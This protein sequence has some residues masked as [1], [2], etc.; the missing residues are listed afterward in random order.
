MK[1]NKLTI[2][3]FETNPIIKKGKKLIPLAEFKGPI[4]KLTTHDKQEIDLLENQL[5]ELD[6][7]YVTILRYVSTKRNINHLL[8]FYRGKLLDIKTSMSQIK[9]QIHNIKIAR[10]Q[11]QIASKN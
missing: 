3:N 7:E 5:H 11:E 2:T 9:K 8:D 1:I 6:L 10:Y 4:L